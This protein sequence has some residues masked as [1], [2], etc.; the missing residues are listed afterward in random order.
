MARPTQS[1][2]HPPSD[3]AGVDV[4]QRRKAAGIPEAE[5]H[6]P[7]WQLALECV[8]EA[9]SWGLRPPPVAV[10]DSGYGDCAEFRHG[11]ST[12][13][14]AYAVQISPTFTMLPATATRTTAPYSIRCRRERVV[15]CQN[16]ACLP[17]T[18]FSAKSRVAGMIED[19]SSYEE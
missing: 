5:H 8:D 12:R 13:N 9:L 10:A 2:P 14:I 3:K 16:T 4:A 19:E 7:K 11:L 17:T 6:R 15:S 1:S 18:L